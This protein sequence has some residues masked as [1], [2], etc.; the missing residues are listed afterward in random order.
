MQFNAA[1]KKINK[2]NN[3]ILNA[4]LIVCGASDRCQ[5]TV[6]GNMGI[7]AAGGPYGFVS[8]LVLINKN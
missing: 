5:V 3:Q 1:A 8:G 4:W 7:M 2:N 6:G